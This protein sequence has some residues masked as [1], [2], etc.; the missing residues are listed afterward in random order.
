MVGY[1][2]SYTQHTCIFMKNKDI[3][4]DQYE[5]SINKVY[6]QKAKNWIYFE[7]LWFKEGYCC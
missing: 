3:N 4:F 5:H 6:D 7:S 2:H 1:I